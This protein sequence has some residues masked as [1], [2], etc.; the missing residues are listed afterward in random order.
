MNN[1]RHVTRPGQSLIRT[2][3]IAVLA[4]GVGLSC[5]RGL[6]PEAI[7]HGAIALSSRPTGA[8]VWLDTTATGD[9]TDCVLDSVTVGKHT[10]TLRRSGYPAWVGTVIVIV[11]KTETLNVTLV[12]THGA[13]AVGSTPTGA[14]VWLDGA[15]T[16]DSTDC[17]LDSVTPGVHALRLVKTGFADW[18]GNIT[19]VAGQTA[20]VSATLL[21]SFGS[22]LVGSTPTG[23]RILLDSVNTG[24]VTNYLLSNVAAGQ[25]NVRLAL[26]GYADWDT[27]VSVVAGQMTTVNAILGQAFGSLQVNS[28]PT[29]AAVWLD[30]TNTGDTTNCLLDSLVPGPHALQLRKTGY[31]NWDTTV[32]VLA[33]QTV[34]VAGRLAQLLGVLRVRSTPT[35]A[36]VWLDNSNTGDTTDC[37]LDSVTPGPHDVELKLTGYRQW[38]TTLTVTAN[39][40]A[41]IDVTLTPE[42]TGL[43]YIGMNA[44]GYAEYLLVKDSSVLIKIPAGTFTMGSTQNPDE[45]PVHDV[46]LDEFYVDKYEISNRQYRRFCDATGKQHPPDPEFPGMSNYFLAYP[47]YPVV[48]VSWNDAMDYLTWT[49]KDLTTETQWEKAARGSDERTYPWGNSYPDWTRCNIIDNDGYEFTSPVG[50]FPDGASFYGAMDMAGNVWEW[51]KDWYSSGYYSVSPDSNPPGPAY[52]STK[53]ARSGSFNNTPIWVRCAERY[54]GGPSTFDEAL[55]FRGARNSQAL[56]FRQ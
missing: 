10:I 55:G 41:S 48:E 6:F 40:T 14:H 8:S 1:S 36:Q 37:L 47:D 46:Y 23:A 56:G 18:Y 15:D 20:Q 28:V 5:R 12:A 11:G 9:T 39:D 38:D 30:G 24:Q 16:R 7:H 21:S 3:A 25:H 22:L 54:W 33:N 13:I 32:T 50:Q 4:L 29:G 51:I 27:T 34:T 43:V 19:V 35:G 44:Q 31:A 53:V 52:G 17:T 42:D 26:D 2:A 49:G 45:Q